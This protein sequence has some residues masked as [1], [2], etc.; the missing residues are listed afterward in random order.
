MSSEETSLGASSIVVAAEEG[1]GELLELSWLDLTE[2]CEETFLEDAAS[3]WAWR[4]LEMAGA[5]AAGAT[6][7]ATSEATATR[8]SSA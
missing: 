5:T 3:I 8:P 1:G 7:S 6:A 4:P 2:V